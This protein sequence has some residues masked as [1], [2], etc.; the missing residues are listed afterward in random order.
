M[1]AR[2]RELLVRL[3]QVNGSIGEIVLAL[4]AAQDG[5][6]LPAQPLREVGEALQALGTDMVARAHESSAH[7]AIEATDV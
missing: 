6:E 4:M 7:P 1:I 5:G 3:G 2:D